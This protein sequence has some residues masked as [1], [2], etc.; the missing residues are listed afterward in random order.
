[1][2]LT[3]VNIFPLPGAAPVIASTVSSTLSWQTLG[4]YSRSNFDYLTGSTFSKGA[5]FLLNWPLGF[6]GI[7][8]G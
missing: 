1:M 4:A 8:S 3:V 5:R 6:L 2:S 7:D